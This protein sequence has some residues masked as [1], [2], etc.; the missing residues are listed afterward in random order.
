MKEHELSLI[1]ARFKIVVVHRDGKLY[2]C[3][4]A[5]DLCNEKDLPFS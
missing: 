4:D 2:K 1:I 3:H 5:L